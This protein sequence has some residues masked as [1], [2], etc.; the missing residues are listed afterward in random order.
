ME[1]TCRNCDS[2]SVL[3]H[4][5][6]PEGKAMAPRTWGME[7]RSAEPLRCKCVHQGQLKNLAWRR[8]DEGCGGWLQT[9]EIIDECMDCG[10]RL[11]EYEGMGKFWDH[12]DDCEHCGEG[13]HGLDPR[14]CGMC[15]GHGAVFVSRD[16]VSWHVRCDACHGS[17][18]PPMS[19]EQRERQRIQTEA[20][21]KNMKGDLS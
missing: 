20:V 15:Q 19:P 5:S 9:R 16:G 18:T 2:W 10:A 11:W 17:G 12:G 4:W 3:G 8:A 14:D 1:K 7:R 6:R 13:Y 21:L